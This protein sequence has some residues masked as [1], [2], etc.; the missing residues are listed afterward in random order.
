[1]WCPGLE[2]FRRSGVC[3]SQMT[4]VEKYLGRHSLRKPD[5]E[6]K[7]RDGVTVKSRCRVKEGVVFS[8]FLR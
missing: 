4:G 3:G 6:R 5:Q 8:V 2:H 1:M 7:E